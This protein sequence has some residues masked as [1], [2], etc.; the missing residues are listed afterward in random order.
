V[1]EREIRLEGIVRASCYDPSATGKQ[2]LGAAIECSDGTVWVIDYNEQ[3]Q[4]H[5]FA[6]RHV[7]VFGEPYRPKGQYLI[8]WEGGKQLGHFR[9][10]TIRVI[11]DVDE[12]GTN[13]AA[14]GTALNPSNDRRKG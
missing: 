2:F 14:H 8:G 11:E 9:V 5:A 13:N 1:N 12:T 10:S 4:F 7:V 6:G 3:S